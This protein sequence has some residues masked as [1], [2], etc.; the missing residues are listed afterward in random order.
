M[1][2]FTSLTEDTGFDLDG[3]SYAMPFILLALSL[4]GSAVLRLSIHATDSLRC[5][6]ERLHGRCTAG[7]DR[8]SSSACCGG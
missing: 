6:T 2:D 3:I 5:P 7:G 8:S 4:F 1:S